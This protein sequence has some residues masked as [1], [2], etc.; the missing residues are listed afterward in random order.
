[1]LLRTVK[2]QSFGLGLEGTT[3]NIIF[4]FFCGFWW[5]LAVGACI[6][7]VCLVLSFFPFLEMIC[8]HRRGWFWFVVKESQALE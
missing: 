2:K 4:S 7:S 8:A 6:G 3:L 5:A 1:M